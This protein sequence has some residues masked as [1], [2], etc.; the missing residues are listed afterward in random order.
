MHFEIRPFEASDYEAVAEIANAI[1]PD[2]RMTAD[3]W[4]NDDRVFE[5][6]HFIRRRYVALDS[7]TGKIV[8]F[9]GI[10]HMP[11]SFHPQKF[12]MQILVHPSFQRRGIG[13]ALFEQLMSD[14]KTLN[15]LSVQVNVREKNREAIAFLHKRGFKEIQRFWELKL[16]VA[17]FELTKFLPVVEQVKAQGIAIVTLADEQRFDSDCMRKLYELQRT[18]GKEV[19]I[20]GHF[21]FAPF[22]DFVRWME[23]PNLLP[24]AFFIAK[25]GNEYIGI[26]NLALMRTDETACLY[27]E[28]TG[29]LSRYRRRKIATALKI[30]AIEYAKRNGFRCIIT[31]NASDSPTML[32]LNE[33]LGFKRRLGIVKMEREIQSK[34]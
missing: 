3:E 4:R 11:L 30:K 5:G 13:N 22:D 2:L 1:C 14:L 9:G 10:S 15:A 31:H 6:N 17:Q 33:K 16:D 8:G 32:A 21:T 12:R 26:S 20:S 24:D 19:P 28:Q 7:S 27:Q 34:S 23:R 18:I 29:V 25:K